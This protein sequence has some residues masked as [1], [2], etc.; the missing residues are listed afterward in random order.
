[1]LPALAVG[2]LASADVGTDFEGT[3]YEFLEQPAFLATV[4]ALG[5]VLYVAERSGP[6]R[7]AFG[8][9]AVAGAVLGALL[10]AG[11]LEAGGHAAAPGLVAGAVC[12]LLGLA[13][14]ATYLE[15]TRRRLDE[16]AAPLLR[17]YAD[18]ASLVIAALAVLFPP[19]SFVVLALFVR[20][21]IGARR[22]GDRRYEG[23]RILR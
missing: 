2:A 13:A 11:S 10:F 7:A 6:N 3:P 5:V 8:I 1:M 22:E 9:A 23:L 18:L 19:L 15:R 21:L 12:A 20:L 14:T 4:F 17:V 16:Q